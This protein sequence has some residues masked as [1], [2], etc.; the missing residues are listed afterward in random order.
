MPWSSSSPSFG[1][2]TTSNR[3]LGARAS[4]TSPLLRA[5][6]VRVPDS[7]NYALETGQ[8]GMLDQLSLVPALRRAPGP[9]EVEKRVRASGLNFRDVVSALGVDVTPGRE[10]SL[11]LPLGSEVP[12][13]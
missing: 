13:S 3:S 7:E 5:K 2:R 12:A 11:R 6:P 10:G 4:A 9:G 1:F 8:K